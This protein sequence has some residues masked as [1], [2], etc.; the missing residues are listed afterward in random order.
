[1]R[2]GNAAVAGHAGVLAVGHQHRCRE[3]ASKQRAAP[4]ED[5]VHP[6][7]LQS[8]PT[9]LSVLIAP[10][11]VSAMFEAAYNASSNG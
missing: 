7:N 5:P 9:E 4:R 6:S 11:L 1:M 3:P 10:G 8:P 2:T